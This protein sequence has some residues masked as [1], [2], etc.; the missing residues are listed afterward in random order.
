M[1]TVTLFLLL[2]PVALWNREKLEQ[3]ALIVSF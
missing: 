1:M 3:S 2:Q